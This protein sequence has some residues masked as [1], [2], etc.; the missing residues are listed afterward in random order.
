[1]SFLSIGGLS[2]AVPG[3]LRAYKKAYDEFGGGVPWEELFLPTIRLCR[4]G[5][6]VSAP[7]ATAIRK[8]EPYILK[9]PTLRLIFLKESGN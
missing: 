9:D 4:Q 5:F 6:I 1:M 2:I 3:E 8:I 7:Q